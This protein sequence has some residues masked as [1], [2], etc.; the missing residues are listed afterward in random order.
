MR[1]WYSDRFR[2]TGAFTEV[3]AFVTRS[4]VESEA[5]EIFL[6]PDPGK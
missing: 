1:G 3:H 2:E 4:G 6:Y 5:R